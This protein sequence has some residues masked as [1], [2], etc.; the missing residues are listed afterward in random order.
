MSKA[1]ERVLLLVGSPKGLEESS[2]ARL[3][4]LVVDGLEERGW[5]SES[6]HLH[7][8]VK[9]EEGR[10]ELFE[11]ID[12]ANV[13]VFATPLYVDSLPA[14]AIRTLELIAAHRSA[15]DVKRVP[16]F[17]S[18][19]HCGFVEPSQND[20]CQRIL[21]RFADRAGFE[22]VAGVSLGG[23]GR[24]PKRVRSAFDILVEALDLE[25]LVPGEVERLTRK[26][27]MA[28]WLYVIGGN[29]GWK[30]LAD[31]SGVKDQLRAQ[32]YKRARS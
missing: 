6:I 7:A 9:S 20:T 11:A 5:T 8:A 13:V 19:V 10:Q 24:I 22:R 27:L 21:L 25:I 18:I 14:P 31:K 16:R 23:G 15:S 4:R 1:G 17:V 32:P 2:S 26:P 29:M 28:G 3:G 12:R 30:R